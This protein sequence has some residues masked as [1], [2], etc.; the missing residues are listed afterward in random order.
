[1]VE[2]NEVRFDSESWK[3]L[4][5]IRLRSRG[6]VNLPSART[7]TRRKCC[8]PSRLSPS[9][10]PYTTTGSAVRC[11]QLSKALLVGSEEMARFSAFYMP[12]LPAHFRCWHHMLHNFILRPRARGKRIGKAG[13]LTSCHRCDASAVQFR[14]SR[15][16]AR[17]GVPITISSSSSFL[18]VVQTWRA[19]QTLDPDR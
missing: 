17:S 7:H 5:R 3:L 12:S 6:R 8:E 4:R 2:R 1:M 16:V 13:R 9:S 15:A 11:L 19:R 10:A 14:F 18:F